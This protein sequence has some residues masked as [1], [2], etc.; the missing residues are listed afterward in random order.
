MDY[1]DEVAW[2]RAEYVAENLI[3][4]AAM[5]NTD[6]ILKIAEVA[7]RFYPGAT[8]HICDAGYTS[9][10]EEEDGVVENGAPLEINVVSDADIY[11]FLKTRRIGEK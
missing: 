4:S 3:D 1:L 11:D 7:N 10:E 8:W 9:S 6:D 2:G 5:S